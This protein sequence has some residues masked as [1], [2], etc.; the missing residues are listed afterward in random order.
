VSYYANRAERLRL[1][2]G[3]LALAKFLKENEEVPTPKHIDVMIFPHKSNDDAD[4]CEVDRI[5][6]LVGV[7]TQTSAASH[8]V[9]SCTFGPIEYRAIAIPASPQEAQG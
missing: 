6:A 8:Y 1:I 3:L 7:T 9:A 4:R 2:A 5:A